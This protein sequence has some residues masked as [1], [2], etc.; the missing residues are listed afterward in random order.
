V[1]RAGRKTKRLSRRP[2][3]VKPTLTV[4]DIYYRRLTGDMTGLAPIGKA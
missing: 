2:K 4:A 3:A 1:S